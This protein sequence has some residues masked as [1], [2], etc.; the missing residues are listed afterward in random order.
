MS[1][2]ENHRGPTMRLHLV[3]DISCD[4]LLDYSNAL[5]THCVEILELLILLLAGLSKDVQIVKVEVR[6]SAL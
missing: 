2:Y 4:M 1:F 6:G 3:D 5:R